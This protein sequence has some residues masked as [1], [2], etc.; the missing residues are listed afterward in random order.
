MESQGYY[1]SLLTFYFLNISNE[2]FCC[3]MIVISTSNPFLQNMYKNIQNSIPWLIL[4]G[5]G[6][7]ADILVTLIDRGCWDADMVQEL[8]INTFTNGLHS[9]EIPCWVKLVKDHL[10]FKIVRL[11]DF[12]QAWIMLF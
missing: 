5:S 6:G 10:C 11:C 7:V 3:S 9:T 12:I 8:L 4:A 1:R 2:V